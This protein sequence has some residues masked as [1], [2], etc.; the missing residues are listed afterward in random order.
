LSIHSKL[1]ASLATAALGSALLVLAPTPAASAAPTP[2][3]AATSAAF[4]ASPTRDTD[5]LSAKRRA[6]IIAARSIYMNAVDHSTNTLNYDKAR[7]YDKG[8]TEARREFA[9][10]F[11]WGHR[12]VTHL[13]TAEKAKVKAE[14]PK[15]A[16]NDTWASTGGG[17]GRVAARVPKPCT[18]VTKVEVLSYYSAPDFDVKQWL[19]SCNTDRLQLWMKVAAG[20]SGVLALITAPSIAGPMFFG[21]VAG[22]LLLGNDLLDFYQERSTDNATIVRDTDHYIRIYSQ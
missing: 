17:S 4:P 12:R 20:L 7:K 6:K 19:N 2:P 1:T 8:D 18:G 5:D 9:A 15:A 16:R 10:A 13:S 21:V 11:L 22:L 14:T 3:Q